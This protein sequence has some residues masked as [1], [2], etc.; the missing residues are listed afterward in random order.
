M[1]KSGNRDGES[2]KELC[3]HAGGQAANGARL[4]AP[5][6]GGMLSPIPCNEREAWTNT[7][8]AWRAGNRLHGALILGTSTCFVGGGLGLPVDLRDPTKHSTRRF[9]Q[10]HLGRSTWLNKGGQIDIG[11]YVDTQADKPLVC[12]RHC[13]LGKCHSFLTPFFSPRFRSPSKER[14]LFQAFYSRFGFQTN[15]RPAETDSQ[16]F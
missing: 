10:K 5:I 7:G 4:P 16:V 15:W 9:Y 2:C 13:G 12:T 8:K 3:R 14:L 1:S 6:L 11:R